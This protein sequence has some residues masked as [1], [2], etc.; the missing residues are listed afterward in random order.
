MSR[1]AKEWSEKEKSKNQSIGESRA[2][3]EIA[4]RDYLVSERS[5]KSGKTG[6]FFWITVN[7]KSD[8]QLEAL[9]KGTEKIV[10]KTWIQSYAYVYENTVSNHIHSHILLKADYE[11]ARA[12]KETANSVKHICETSNVHCFKFV[13]LDEDKAKQKLSYMMGLKAPK[14]LENV[15]LTREWRKTVGLEEIYLSEVPLI[16]LEPRKEDVSFEE[17]P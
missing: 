9:M 8:V 7:P 15:D 10:S 3:Q 2:V 4:F 12:R 16:L 1:V 14:K 5:E 13:I 6:K 11:T 17:Q